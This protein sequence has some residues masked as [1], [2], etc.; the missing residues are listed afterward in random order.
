M[1]VVA[2]E[3]NCRAAAS[4]RYESGSE[5]PHSGLG[6]FLVSAGVFMECGGLP[7]LQ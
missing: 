2:V 1:G 4:R 3:L 7:P 5:L 6:G